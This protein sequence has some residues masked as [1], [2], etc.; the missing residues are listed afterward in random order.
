MYGDLNEKKWMYVYFG[1]NLKYWKL[2][3]LQELSLVPCRI[4]FFYLKSL[5]LIQA[6][7]IYKWIHDLQNCIEYIVELT[8]DSA[9]VFSKWIATQ[10]Q[11][12]I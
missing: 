1:Y 2:G 8:S 6:L 10:R 11:T 3:L 9:Y 7:D 4:D 12:Y 5:I